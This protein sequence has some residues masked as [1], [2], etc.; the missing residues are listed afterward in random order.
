MEPHETRGLNPAATIRS[1]Y[2]GTIL[3]DE[4]PHEAGFI[5]QDHSGAVI[6][7]LHPSCAHA[8]Q[9]VLM[10][11]TESAP[12]IEVLLEITSE[13]CE[14]DKDRWRVYHGVPDHAG[15]AILTPTCV[16]IAGHMIDPDELELANELGLMVPK[17]CAEINH[18]QEIKDQ[19]SIIV[20]APEDRQ[21][22]CV[23]VDQ[24]GCDLRVGKLLKRVLF[25]QEVH[26]LDDVLA[27][28]A[29]LA[30]NCNP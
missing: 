18:A 7:P 30:K 1:F 23:G 2:T 22:L 29:R 11:P 4:Q 13:P 24:F 17:I 6:C 16:R 8:E 20:Q 25:K 27:Q 26:E 21:L 3:C 5:I 19:L 12:T 15:W 28:I 10:A 9:I 14:A